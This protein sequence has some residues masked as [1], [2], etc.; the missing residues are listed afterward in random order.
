[1]KKK[2]QSGMKMAW[3]RL[4]PPSHPGQHPWPACP[5]VLPLPPP[6][7]AWAGGRG[8]RPGWEPRV[9]RGGL[10]GCWLVQLRP[11]FKIFIPFS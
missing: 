4:P 5:T 2:Q 6:G 11:C 10:V 3:L 7:G 8:G 9:G 1:M